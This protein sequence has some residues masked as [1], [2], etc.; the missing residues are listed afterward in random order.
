LSFGVLSTS[1]AGFFVVDAAPGLVTAVLGLAVG[2][3]WPAFAG[4]FAGVA[5]GLGAV[6][7]LGVVA[8]GGVAA[9][10]AA[11]ACCEG[12]GVAGVSCAEALP[13]QMIA[14]AKMNAANLDSFVMHVLSH[15]FALFANYKRVNASAPVQ[16]RALRKHL[17]PFALQRCVNLKFLFEYL[18]HVKRRQ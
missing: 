7:G 5:A 10:A 3:A 12:G 8:A 13:A 16:H 14:P 9:G 6:A 15:C 17:R 11:G 4:V 2:P 1:G 18:V